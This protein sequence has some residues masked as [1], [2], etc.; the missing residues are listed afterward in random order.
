MSVGDCC[1]IPAGHCVVTGSG[2]SS[3]LRWCVGG[4]GQD[5][6]RTRTLLLFMMDGFPELKGAQHGFFQLY[7]F[8]ADQG[9]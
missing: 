2:G 4:D 9:F 6:S 5:S 7:E 3:V 8:L 1:V